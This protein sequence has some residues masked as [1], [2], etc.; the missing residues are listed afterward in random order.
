M[1]RAR[2]KRTGLRLEMDCRDSVSLL[3]G[4]NSVFGIIAE[5]KV[6][7]FESGMDNKQAVIRYRGEKTDNT[8]DFPKRLEHGT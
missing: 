1:G 5:G 6:S 2:K 4:L 3:K 8:L 7:F